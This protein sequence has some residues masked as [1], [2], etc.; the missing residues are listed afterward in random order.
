MIKKILTIAGSD[1]S[2][3]AGIQADIK[4]IS[5]LG[6]YAMSV[7]CSVTAQN[8][9]GVAAIHDVPP[10]IVSAQMD[11][12]FSDI[13]VDAVKIGMVSNE[14][15]IHAIAEGLSRYKP[16]IIV[17][18]PV[19]VS[20]SG[21]K[22]LQTTAQSALMENLIPLAT[23]VTPNLP[24]AEVLSGMEIKNEDDMEKSLYKIQSLGCENVLIKGGHNG[25]E[26]IDTLLAGDDIY[27]FSAKRVN[28]K[29]THGTGCTLSSAIASCLAK[30]H[31]LR[32]AVA[33]AKDY[34]T[35]ALENSYTVGHGHGPVNHFWINKNN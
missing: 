20:T 19:M 1:S 9:C 2:G 5:A 33:Q 23:V 16:K 13:D 11:A 30:T 29:N 21:H 7:I 28:T 35:Y 22:L 24:E 14:D 17:L 6:C 32:L 3:G 15:N 4:T 27:K 8:T 26:P 25:G 34:L 18:D 10:D 12:V 31:D